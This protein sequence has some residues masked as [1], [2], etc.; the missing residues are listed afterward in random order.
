MPTNNDNGNIDLI[1]QQKPQEP[2]PIELK[3]PTCNA[4]LTFPPIEVETYD[5]PVASIIHVIHPIGQDC[6]GCGG[7]FALRVGIMNGSI[8]VYPASAKKPK[9][10]P[11]II[12]PKFGLGNLEKLKGN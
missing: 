4:D 3:C 6:I 1:H 5:N 10:A 7:Y 8:M 9:E 2:P 11:K 12:K